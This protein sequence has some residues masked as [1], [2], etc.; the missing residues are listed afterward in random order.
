MDFYQMAGFLLNG[1][2]EGWDSGAT[3]ERSGTERSGVGSGADPSP[4]NPNL[5]RRH[6]VKIPDIWKKSN[7]SDD[8]RL[9]SNANRQLARFPMRSRGFFPNSW[10]LPLNNYTS[11]CGVDGV[12]GRLRVRRSIIIS[13]FFYD[14]YQLSHSMRS[15][16]QPV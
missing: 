14:S 10:P 6:S 2:A 8:N 5:E 7:R 15:F 13:A 9:K 1:E 11:F 4:L 12:V 3:G 16:T